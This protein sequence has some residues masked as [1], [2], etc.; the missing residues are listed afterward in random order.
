M[1]ARNELFAYLGSS[2]LTVVVLFGLQ[3]WYAS[4]ID[5][6][7]VHASRA[8]APLDP[9]V[10]AQRERE[11]SKLSGGSMPIAEAKKA[12]AQGGRSAFPR[13]APKPSDDISAMSGWMFRKGFAPY[14]P[15]YTAPATAAG[16]SADQPPVAQPQQPGSAPPAAEPAPA[17]AKP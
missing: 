17:E 1:D 13:I 12:I 10:A 3:Q 6:H 4:Y 14:V 9:K 7:V 5:V 11:R 8:A 2:L 16:T 15:R